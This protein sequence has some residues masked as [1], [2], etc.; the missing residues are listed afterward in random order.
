MNVFN[1][2]NGS[3]LMEERIST[4]EIDSNTKY[5]WIRTVRSDGGYLINTFG[6]KN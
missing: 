1:E 2:L 4:V 6:T 5:F 3:D